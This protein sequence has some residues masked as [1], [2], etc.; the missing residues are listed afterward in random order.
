MYPDK[1]IFNSKTYNKVKTNVLFFLSFVLGQSV[2]GQG[3]VTYEMLKCDKAQ[4]KVLKQMQP[5]AYHASDKFVYKIGDTIVLGSPS[6]SHTTAVASG[7]V[8][9]ASS[10]KNYSTI[11]SDASIAGTLFTG[12]PL[13]MADR[14]GEYFIIT[15]LKVKL[16]RKHSV[17][18][19]TIN[20]RGNVRGVGSV[21]IEN[22]EKAIAYGEVRSKGMTKDRAIMLLKEAKEHLDLELMTQEEYNKRKEELLPYI[23]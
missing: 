23:K 7:N 21:T 9:V 12:V 20:L 4:A 6:S 1:E 15:N 19:A 10:Q 22:F 3:V 14:S 2:F 16:P 5:T 13:Y 8:A 17:D 11:V 18:G